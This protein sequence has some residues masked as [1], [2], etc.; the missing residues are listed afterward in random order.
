MLWITRGLSLQGYL[1]ILHLYASII[2]MKNKCLKINHIF[3]VRSKILLC[4]SKKK[5]S[6]KI[7][8]GN[9]NIFLLH[10]IQAFN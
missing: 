6:K 9:E 5:D 7:D 2:F 4:L 1:A 8:T 10:L 3:K